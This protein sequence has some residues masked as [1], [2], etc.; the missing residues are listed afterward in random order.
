M[1]EFTSIRA[2]PVARIRAYRA[3]RNSVIVLLAGAI[4]CGRAE[5]NSAAVITPPNA[6]NRAASTVQMAESLAVATIRLTA[7]PTQNPF[8]NRQRADLI[9]ARIVY[10]SGAEGLEDRLTLADERL[11]AGDSR[12]AIEDLARLKDLA[13]LTN[14]SISERTKPFFDI[15]ALAYLRLG[16]Q[17]NCIDNPASNVCIL[18]LAGAAIHVRQ[19][20]ARGAIARFTE[21]L[22]HFPNDYGSRWLLNIAYMQVG[23]YPDSVPPAY[24]IPDLRP[25]PNDPFP[26]FTNIAPYLGLNIN[27]RAGALSIDDF[28]GDGLLDIFTTAWGFSDP[29]HLFLADGKG[30]Y[31]DRGPA[32]GLEGITGGNNTADADFDN[33]GNVD[34]LVTRGGWLG[35]YG[36]FPKSLL[37]NRGDGSFEDVT[38]KAGLGALH[39]SQTAAWADFNLDGYV[40][41]FVGN[42]SFARINKS[43]SHRSQLFLN[44]GNGTFTDVSAKVGI[45]VDDFV[46]GVTWGDVNNDGLPD[47]YISVLYGKNKLYVNKGGTSPND[48]HFEE[49]AAAAGVEL[50]F[51]SFP[52]WFWDFDEDGWDDLLVLS[53]DVDRNMAD[54][55]AREYLKLP[56]ELER[57]GKKIT[58]E[59]SRLYRNN[60]NGTFTDVTRSAGLTGK[61]IYAMGANFGDLDNDGYPDFYVG[62]GNPDMRSIIP[63]RMF[64]NVRGKRFEEVTL[65]GGFGHLQKGHAPVFADLDRDG[66]EDIYE[67]IGGAYEGDRYASVLFENPGWPGRSWLSLKLEGRTASRSAIGARIEVA[68]VDSLGKPRTVYRTVSTG[69]SFGTGSL[70]QH[71]GLGAISRVRSVTIHW[72]DAARSVTVDSNITPNATYQIVQGQS[73][74]LLDRPPIAFRKEPPRAIPMSVHN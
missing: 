26:L 61:A 19:E 46:K 64:H 65:P 35:E 73:A 10:E 21:L 37:R 7:D 55:V 6:S 22:R 54:M 32:A 33:D 2:C 9:Q 39:P 31:V 25:K 17:E 29:M 57:D 42:E 45:D 1:R 36:R 69:G 56:L 58:V 23:G 41:L 74:R 59:S 60:H 27:G 18:P 71:I 50:P 38:F 40:D 66:D 51:S 52:A 8:L 11:R 16:E 4:A 53:Y 43:P 49:R 62:T 15:E 47:L 68:V 5:S 14:D 63:N 28:N 13:H 72:P 34:I 12:R 48:W 30:G 24:R 67:I 70:Q 3:A 44:N 20:G